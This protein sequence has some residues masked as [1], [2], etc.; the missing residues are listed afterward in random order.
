MMAAIPEFTLSSFL[1]IANV[2][3]ML[4]A[5]YMFST[6]KII[7][8]SVSDQL[9]EEA[10]NQ[11]LKLVNEIIERLEGAVENGVRNAYVPKEKTNKE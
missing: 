11:T 7:A 10:R 2:S 9:L 5:L 6:G 3:F 8:K 1:E 4:L